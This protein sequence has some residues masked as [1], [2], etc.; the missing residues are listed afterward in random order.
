VAAKR[1]GSLSTKCQYCD[2][3]FDHAADISRHFNEFHP[4]QFFFWGVSS[5]FGKNKEQAFDQWLSE[6]SL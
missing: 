1:R 6:Q 2:V 3:V 4:G 5:F